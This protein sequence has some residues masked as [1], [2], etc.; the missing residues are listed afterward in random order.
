MLYRAFPDA[1]EGEL[2]QRLADLVRK[3]A[4]AEVAQAWQVGPHMRLGPGEIQ[5]GGRRKAAILADICESVI[6]AMFLD[7]GYAAAEAFIER[8]LVGA[9]AE[10]GR[11]GARRQV[12]AAGMGAGPRPAAAGLPR[13]ERTGPDHSPRFTIEV[14]LPGLPSVAGGGRSKRLAEQAAAEEFLV[15]QG[16][17]ARMPSDA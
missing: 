6:G 15:R 5:T 11:P 10:A 3:E 7:A 2:S 12:G 13:V 16:V 1:D 17:I 4:C 14:E 9:H 8:A